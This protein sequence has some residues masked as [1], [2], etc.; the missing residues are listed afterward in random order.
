M[1]ITKSEVTQVSLNTKSPVKIAGLPEVCSVTAF[2]VRLETR[3][4][5]IAWGCAVA[6]P[7]LTGETPQHAYR[8]CL[9]CADLACD[10]NAA[11]IEYSLAQLQSVAGAS[12]AARCA[13]DLAF[14]DLLGLVSDL[15]LYRLLGGYRNQIQTSATVPLVGLQE[16]TELA[17]ARAAEGFRILKIKGGC[18]PE[19]DV[20]RVK[21]VHRLL[22]NHRLR[23]DADGQYQIQQALDVAHALRDELEMLEQP[24]PAEDLTALSE[25]TR[26]S[27]VPVLADQSVSDPASALRFAAGRIANGLCVKMSTCGGFTCARQIDSIARAAKMDTLVSCV[28]EPALLI[29]AGLS[30][31]LSTPN[32]RY[33]DLD[34]YLELVDDPSIPSFLLQDGCLTASEV[35]GLGCLVAL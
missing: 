15:P 26:H 5:K 22:P 21:A 23:L 19:E 16:T 12:L 31:S 8:A 1:Q 2:F 29:A 28:I 14:Y 20:Q 32:V 9:A 35:P 11:N 17:C 13:F 6:H 33:C 27:P 7:Q 10:L 3:D 4:R 24:T 25:V 18:D 34:G 30:F